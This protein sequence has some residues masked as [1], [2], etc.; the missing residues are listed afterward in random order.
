MSLSSDDPLF[1]S[2]G[3]LSVF[4]RAAESLSFTEAGRQLGVSSSAIGKSVARL[5]ARLG[6]KLFHRSTRSMTLT[7]EGQRLLESCKLIVGEVE[8]ISQEFA[9]AKG[10]PRGKLRV[11]MPLV[12]MLLSPIISQFMKT[13]PDVEL[14]M[15]FSDDMVDVIADGYDVVIR[16]GD[17][18]DSRL[19]TRILGSYRME[20]VGSPD[21]FAAFGTPQHPEELARHHCL[22]HKYP[23]TGKVRR[24]PFKP[25]PDGSDPVLP[26]TATA[27]TLEPLIA[28]A[29]LGRGIT[30]LPDFAIR[31]QI[32]DG[33]LVR[34]LDEFIEHKGVFRAVWP[35][36]RYLSPKRR[37]FVDFMAEHLFP[38]TSR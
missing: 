28:L 34:V 5:E 18:A 35:S 21:Y 22:H 33:R 16:T 4:V 17:A 24:W 9:H 23:T 11:G 2:L 3:V 12:S 10:A 38:S 1:E 15:D 27:S 13:Y 19:M 7:Q 8:A 31:R 26:V 20:V 14:D 36:S 32:E 6:V 29:E 30:C 37:A 25:T